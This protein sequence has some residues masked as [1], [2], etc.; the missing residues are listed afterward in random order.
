M[1]I[2][3]SYINQFSNKILLPMVV[4]LTILNTFN[5]LAQQDSIKVVYSE[6]NKDSSN[7]MF[8]Q[9]YRYI[10]INMKNETDLLKVGV[11]TSAFLI[12]KRGVLLTY[13]KK[14]KPSLSILGKTFME[15]AISDDIKDVPSTLGLTIESRWYH[16]INKKM[17]YGTSG[18]NFHNNYLCF[19]VE[20]I[21]NDVH[22]FITTMG[23]G[24]QKRLNNIG[25]IDV[26]VRLNTTWLNTTYSPYPQFEI[27][28]FEE[29]INLEIGFGVNFRKQK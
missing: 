21:W 5:A 16:L 10:D 18:N 7:Y 6:E 8:R 11:Q 25:Y 27:I 26:S 20:K 3:K 29:T 1:N 24:I 28:D 2:M 9:K 15:S 23:W 14:L 17:K 4:I 13:E 12:S 22:R 19:G